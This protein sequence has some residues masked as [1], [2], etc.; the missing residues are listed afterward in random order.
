[1]APRHHEQALVQ[2]RLFGGRAGAVQDEIGQRLV[3][4]LGRAAQHGFLFRR[5]AKAQ[6]G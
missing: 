5:G 1:M 4:H 6:A 2:Q 3:R